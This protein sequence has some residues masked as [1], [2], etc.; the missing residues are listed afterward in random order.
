MV[1]PS[2]HPKALRASAPRATR[3]PATPASSSTSSIE[4]V[5]AAWQNMTSKVEPSPKAHASGSKAPSNASQKRKAKYA[6]R[7]DAAKKQRDGDDTGLTPDDDAELQPHPE[8]GFRLRCKAALFTWNIPENW[9]AQQA[10]ECLQT[11][12]NWKHVKHYTICAEMES[13]WHIHAYLEFQHKVD[14]SS[15]TWEICKTKPDARPNTTSGSG[16][17]QAVKRGSFYVANEFKKSFRSHAMNYYPAGCDPGASYSVKTQWVIDQW[18]QNKLRDAV[19]CAATYKCLTPPFKAMVSMSENVAKSSARKQA[20]LD[21]QQAF[22]AMKLPFCIVPE[23]DDFTTQFKHFQ[24]RYHFMWFWGPSQTGKTEFV[25]SQFHPDTIFVMKGGI[26]FTNYNPDKHDAILFDDCPNIEDF[27]LAKRALF[28]AGSIDN[29]VGN[30]ATNCY[31][32]EV[33]TLGKKLIVCANTGP[34]DPW[35]LANCFVKH[36]HNSLVCKMPERHANTLSWGERQ[37]QRYFKT[38]CD[39]VPTSPMVL[40]LR[41][42]V[43]NQYNWLSF[44]VPKEPRDFDIKDYIP[45][46]PVIVPTP[47]PNDAITQGLV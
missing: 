24:K 28:Q 23:W 6:P 14:H 5:D 47:D 15:W 25:L 2:Q 21:H 20:T 38:M 26:N 33:D 4:I 17:S 35:T 43:Y 32:M 45:S 40:N 37:F 36:A 12:P 27:I 8:G 11:L 41:N 16:F 1:V 31:A 7:P 34:S 3:P 9:S 22:E 44:N 13:H 29:Q 10:L 42:G 30:S 46:E 39:K 19:L 18:S